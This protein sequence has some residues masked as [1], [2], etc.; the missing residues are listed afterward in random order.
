MYPL[1]IL[2]LYMFIV[3]DPL[4]SFFPVCFNHHSVIYTANQGLLAMFASARSSGIILDIGDGQCQRVGV[5]E[6]H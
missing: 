1:L 3:Q 4:F 5:F 6:G 2:V